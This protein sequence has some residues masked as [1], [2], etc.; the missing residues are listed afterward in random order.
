MQSAVSATLGR[1]AAFALMVVA[2]AAGLGTVLTA[3]EVIFNIVKWC[4]VV[5]LLWLGARTIVTALR[6][7]PEQ[8]ET[9]GDLPADRQRPAE[10]PSRQRQA[11][12]RLASQE[13]LVAASNPKALVLFAVFLPQF[14]PNGAEN[15]ALPLLVLGATYIGVEFCCALG[16]A[17]AG[18]WLKGKGSGSGQPRRSM[19]VFTGVA[20]I[21]LA[22]WLATENR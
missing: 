13:F 22:G 7:A 2:V 9:A 18:G 11:S 10:E 4:G 1:F 5:Y 21:G 19:N 20:M 6:K 12:W 8:Q 17:A 3:S 14:L 15:V 16:Y